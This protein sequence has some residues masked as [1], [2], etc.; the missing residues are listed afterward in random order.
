MEVAL[1]LVKNR[2]ALTG[3]DTWSFGP[4]PSEDP[5]APFVVPQTLNVK[6]GMFIVENLFTSELSK[7]KVYEFLFILTHPKVRGATG[8]WVSPLAVV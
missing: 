5:D 6:H 8:G 7:D 4:V 3:C 1:E 2:V